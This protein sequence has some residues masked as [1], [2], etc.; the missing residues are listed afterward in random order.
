MQQREQLILKKL[1]EAREAQAH[2]LTRF[3]QARTRVMEVEARLQA[4][5]AHLAASHPVPAE[6][7]VVAPGANAD[8]APPSV[9]VTPPVLPTPVASGSRELSG[10]PPVPHPMRE[11]DPPADQESE[12]K[13]TISETP[14]TLLDPDSSLS[15]DDFEDEEDTKKRPAISLARPA[16]PASSTR[17]ALDEEETLILTHA[18]MRAASESERE[19]QG[20]QADA[21]TDAG[22]SEA[23]DITARIPVIRQEGR[24]SQEE[25]P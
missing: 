22:S 18:E 21:Q 19:N 6:P 24:P 14:T 3:I 13:Q 20:T 17:P 2:T 7:D 4:I 23:T 10:D 16:S 8:P 9:P 12:E 5:R 15:L 25:H 11:T 1:A